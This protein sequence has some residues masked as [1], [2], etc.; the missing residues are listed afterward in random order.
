MA[1][2]NVVDLKNKTV[3]SI[4]LDDAVWSAEPRRYL[5]TEVVHWQRAKRRR[6]TQSTLTK[7]EVNGSVAKPY[8]QKGTGQARQGNWKNPHMVGGG[9]AFAPKPRDY[10]YKMPKAK[11][12][13]AL[14][15]ALSLKLTEG[16]LTIVKDFALGEIKTKSVI[17]ALKALGRDSA[18]IVDGDN[19]TLKLSTRNLPDSRY[20]HQDGINVYDLLK[21][22]SLIVTESA[23]K[24][25]EARLLGEGT[26]A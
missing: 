7:A 14:A 23:A 21:Y 17:A 25:I 1:K 6:G 9:V 5:L 8:G 19:E 15:T 26:E 18:L 4:E 13:A 20:L 2:F 22:P 11:R 16:G 10:S 24:A 3:G 12:R